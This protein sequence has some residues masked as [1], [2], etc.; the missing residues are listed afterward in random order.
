LGYE[1]AA[2]NL[3]DAADEFDEYVERNARMQP[4][5]SAV[6]KA[7]GLEKHLESVIEEINS[8]AREL[9]AADSVPPG[10]LQIESAKAPGRLGELFYLCPL[11]F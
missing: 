9:K 4:S 2:T 3:L 6:T 10:Q 5:A 11:T 8:P 1:D 7:R